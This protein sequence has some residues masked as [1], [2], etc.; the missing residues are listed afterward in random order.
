MTVLEQKIEQHKSQLSQN[1]AKLEQLRTRRAKLTIVCG[2]TAD[3]D[4]EI[5]ALRETIENSPVVESELKNQSEQEKV[6]KQNL[7]KL[8]KQQHHTAA[9]IEK[10]SGELMDALGRAMYLNTQLHEKFDKYNALHKQTSK[11]VISQRVTRGSEG[12]LKFVYD[13]CQQ[14][15][16]G[17]HPGRPILPQPCP[18]I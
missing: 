1:K 18:R 14:E 7:D 9:D 10:L 12:M 2:S 8:I 5:A 16:R 13:I 4:V 3:I 6:T 17:E 15:M 11:D